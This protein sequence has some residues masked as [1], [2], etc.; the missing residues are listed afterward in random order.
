[1]ATY[2]YTRE[3]LGSGRWDVQH[4]DR[5]T[6]LAKEIETAVPGK[7]FRLRCSGTQILVIT[8][9]AW[10]GGEQTTLASTVAAHKANS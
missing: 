10:S 2:E 6:Q 1:M 7:T 9:E 3:V 8:D 4:P 5:G